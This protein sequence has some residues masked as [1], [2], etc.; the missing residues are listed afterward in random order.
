LSLTLTTTVLGACMR[1]DADLQTLPGRNR[2]DGLD[3]IAD[4][5]RMTCSIW[6]DR[7]ARLADRS[8]APGDLDAGRDE[9]GLDEPTAVRTTRASCHAFA[10]PGRAR[11]TS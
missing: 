4:R 2:T 8:R 7:P 6:I 11:A 1:D 5:L 3:G 9:L 10:F